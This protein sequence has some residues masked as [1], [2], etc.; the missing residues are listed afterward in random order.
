MDESQLMHCFDSQGDFSH[1][2]PRDVFRKDLILDEHGHQIS[3]GQKLHQH[4]QECRVLE[5]GVQFDEPRAVSI[6]K[7]VALGANVGKLIFF[8]LS[9][10]LVSIDIMNRFH[11][12][13]ISALTSDFS[14]Y[15]LP[16]CRLCTS[17]TSPKAPLPMIFNV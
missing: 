9:V 3:T 8:V 10:W 1:I 14:A 12:R 15:T 2:E 16:S 13:T 11:R 7:D 4:V 17:L 5:R 6:G